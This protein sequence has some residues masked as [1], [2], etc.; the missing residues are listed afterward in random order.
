[1]TLLIIYLSFS[2]YPSQNI[3]AQNRL[4]DT[5]IINELIDIAD[6]ILANE[7][8]SAKVLIDSAMVIAEKLDVE[9]YKIK[10]LRRRV[11]AQY[12]LGRYSKTIT[13]LFTL[14]TYYET[15]KDTVNIAIVYND[16]GT[17]YTEMAELPLAL[18]YLQKAIIVREEKGTTKERTTTLANIGL[19]Y[20]YMEKYEDAHKYLNKALTIYEE[21]NFLEGIATVNSN[22]G[23]AF[24]N[25]SKYNKALLHFNISLK[26]YKKIDN[27]D[28]IANTLNN[29]GLLYYYWGNYKD[30]I[31]YFEKSAKI[32]SKMGD[33]NGYLYAINN[34]AHVYKKQENYRKS[35]EYLE[36]SLSVANKENDKRIMTTIVEKTALV[37]SELG[38]YK[39]AYQ[40]QLQYHDLYNDVVNTKKLEQIEEL[41]IEFE[42]EQKEA[43]ITNLKEVTRIQNESLQQRQIII[44][45]LVGTLIL[46][47]LIV[48]FGITRYR[49]KTEQ[50]GLKLEQQTL[51]LEQRLLRSQMN[52]HF[53][54]NSLS[55]IQA[56]IFKGSAKEAAGYLSSFAKLM[57]HILENSQEEYISLSKEIETL[58][59][60]LRLQTIKNEGKINYS[61]NIK[62]EIE[63][64]NISVP[65]MLAQPFIENSIKHGLPGN[66]KINIFINYVLKNEFILLSIE[67][68]GIGINKS[69]KNLSKQKEN[70]NSLAISIT[71]SRLQLLNKGGK[72]KFNF[73]TTDISEENPNKTGTRIEI[74]IPYLEEF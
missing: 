31:N 23:M 25:E 73:S 2:F 3:Q 63:L 24:N 29:I 71:K 1:M 45:L 16:I 57:R 74:E 68:D 8:K 56:Y 36:K 11:D 19:A 54:F 65:P 60:Y 42:T 40:Y 5:L 20:I 48:Y 12:Y 26:T 51:K 39:N 49:L 21:I 28:G 18:E 33:S 44:F 58:E 32:R 59:H 69:G 72:K 22:I 70:H 64:E 14:L 53:I 66:G 55:V 9:K 27:L 17:T 6:S 41:K 7:P 46:L 37:Y 38:D 30:A 15:L 52:P 67:D 47:G 34:I 62:D 10:I 50:K 35:L 13:D 61:I 43:E 4:N